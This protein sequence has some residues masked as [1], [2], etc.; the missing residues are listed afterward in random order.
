MTS[1]GPGQRTDTPYHARY[2]NRYRAWHAGGM[3]A[4]NINFS[5]DELAQIRDRAREEGVS[6]RTLAHDAIVRCNARG[7]RDEVIW[8]AYRESR[9]ISAGLLRRLADR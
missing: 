4:L 5:D 3:P 2:R 7:E 1:P 6:M 8:T 9:P